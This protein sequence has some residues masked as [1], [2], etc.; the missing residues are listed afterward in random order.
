MIRRLVA[1]LVI[2]LLLILLVRTCGSLFGSGEEPAPVV[3]E[4]PLVT[5]EDTTSSTGETTETEIT[6]VTSP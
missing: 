3:P 2:L 4:K 5:G 6:S 1:I